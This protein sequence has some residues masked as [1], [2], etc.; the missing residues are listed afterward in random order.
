MAFQTWQIG[1]DIQNGQLCALGIQRRRN[2]WQL[3]HWWQHALPDDT[4]TNGILQRA[5]ELIALLSQWRA[6]LP[7]YFSLRV[8]FPP[9]GVLQRQFRLP[10]ASLREPECSRYVS[11]AARRLFPIAP[12]MLALDY[13]ATSGD[14]INITATRKETLSQWLAC[15]SAAGLCADIFELT[16]AALWSLAQVLE[17]PPNAVL[18]HQLSD[19]WLWCGKN[20]T[21]QPP[22]WCSTANASDISALRASYL[23]K[24]SLIYFSADRPGL[25]AG[26]DALRPLEALQLMQ[27]PLPVYSG[28]FSLAMG[29]AFRPEDA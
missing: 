19:H 5:P 10:A 11:A 3:R 25:P 27:P 24:H 15:L 8:G 17:L 29:L 21:T 9:Q 16:P 20:P 22:G 14:E 6:Q 12:E 23:D 26:V 7:R 28:V 2:G 1:L 18:V 4:L 13:R